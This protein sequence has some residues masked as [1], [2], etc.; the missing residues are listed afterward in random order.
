MRIVA[1]RICK[2]FSPMFICV[3]T[4]QLSCN[5]THGKLMG[6]N[7]ATVVANAVHHH[8]QSISKGN[9]DSDTV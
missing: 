3:H 8:N 4:P 6:E 7:M 1:M 5:T 2:S 9:A